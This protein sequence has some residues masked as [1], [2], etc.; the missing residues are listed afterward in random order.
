M[1][2]VNVFPFGQSSGI[3]NTPEM[4]ADKIIEVVAGMTTNIDI[5]FDLGG[6]A[7]GS[8]IDESTGD[9]VEGV[10]VVAMNVDTGE[11]LGEGDITNEIGL[12][13]VDRILEVYTSLVAMRNPS[14]NPDPENKPFDAFAVDDD[15]DNHVPIKSFMPLPPAGQEQ[16]V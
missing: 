8:V 10:N 16:E 9:P 1:Y 3:S 6:T 11:S 13:V 14:D 15:A 5:C 4:L 12:F 2:K 7:R